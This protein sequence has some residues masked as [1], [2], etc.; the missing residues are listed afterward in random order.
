M[1]T[2]K[3]GDYKTKVSQMKKVRLYRILVVVLV[4]V[5]VGAVVIIPTTTTYKN[6]SIAIRYRGYFKQEINEIRQTEEQDGVRGVEKLI[7]IK[8]EASSLK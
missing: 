4:I 5:A 8:A 3:S 6:I 7:D 1:K 2:I